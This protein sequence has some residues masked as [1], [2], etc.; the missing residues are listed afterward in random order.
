VTVTRSPDLGQLVREALE[1]RIA[2]I[3]VSLP[4]KVLS[5]DASK[6]TVN[7]K[8][9]LKRRRINRAGVAKA[10]E[11]EAIQ[12]VPVRFLRGASYHD[13]TPIQKDDVGFVVFADRALGEWSNSPAGTIVEPKLAQAH[14]LSGAWF[15]PGGYPQ[16]SP[17]SP[18]P[19]TQHRV[20]HVD[21]ELH[22]GEANPTEFVAL[23]TKVY[24]EINALRNSVS[25]MVTVFGTHTHTG[26]TPGPGSS[27]TP[28]APQ[29]A[30]AAVNQVA[31]SKVKA[32]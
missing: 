17:I 4:C 10:T 2:E 9:L 6:Q 23:A 5:Y 28:A 18:A 12:N 8:P 14:P 32:K 13:T 26:V 16:A 1:A 30:P 22:L 24:N 29:T 3:H 31:A 21:N 15:E 19:S 11:Y 25:N 27:G 7:V 20:L